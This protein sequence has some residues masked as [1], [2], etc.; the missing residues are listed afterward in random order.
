MPKFWKQFYFE[1]FAQI[2]YS[3]RAAGT[4]F[5]ADDPLDCGHVVKPPSAK[6]VF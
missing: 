1:H 3:G 5:K 6:I 2:A 4:S